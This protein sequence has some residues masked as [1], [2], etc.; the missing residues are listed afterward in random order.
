MI[1]PV[2]AA[3]PASSPARRRGAAPA[4]ASS[5]LCMDRPT[6]QPMVIIPRAESDL[7]IAGSRA[8]SRVGDR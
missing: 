2:C 8:T 1:R 3:V 5:H 4:P 6:V 7:Q